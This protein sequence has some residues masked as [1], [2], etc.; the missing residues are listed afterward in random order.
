M[1]NYESQCPLCGT[2]Q[3]VEIARE[4]PC[5]ECLTMFTYTPTSDEVIGA[6]ARMAAQLHERRQTNLSI[7]E[8]MVIFSVAAGN[9]RP[10]MNAPIDDVDAL[11]DMYD[12][13]LDMSE[14]DN[15]NE[16]EG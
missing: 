2:V 8:N 12:W 6:I 16:Q 14:H 10:G 15:N 13:V 3:S 9:R 11:L 1:I 4:Q 5:I 7:F